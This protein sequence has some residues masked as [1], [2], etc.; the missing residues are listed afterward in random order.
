MVDVGQNGPISDGGMI[1]NTWLYRNLQAGQLDLPP[2]Q[3]NGGGRYYVI[4]G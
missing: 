1:A 2:K 3:G 4:I